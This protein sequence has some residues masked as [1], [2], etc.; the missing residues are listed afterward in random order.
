MS[1]EGPSMRNKENS[2]RLM[3]TAMV[4]SNQPSMQQMQ[5]QQPMWQQ[6][7]LQPLQPTVQSQINPIVTWQNLFRN[8]NSAYGGTAPRMARYM[9]ALVNHD[10][11]EEVVYENQLSKEF[12]E[13]FAEDYP[14]VPEFLE[15]EE[16][17]EENQNDVSLEP[18]I[19]FVL[20]SGATHHLVNKQ[21]GLFNLQFFQKPKN[22]QI[23]KKASFLNALA[24]GQM[25]LRTLTRLR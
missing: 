6:Q 22:I 1:R 17:L 8:P 15:F 10:E 7:Q 24:I 3:G 18:D 13:N 25:K 5:Y 4:A 14:D 12:A 16:N 19:E 23:A 2:F 11:E 21:D 9:A 20:D